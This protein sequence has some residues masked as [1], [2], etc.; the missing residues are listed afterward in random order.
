MS[1]E[2]YWQSACMAIYVRHISRSFADIAALSDVGFTARAGEI[3][4]FA[5]LRRFKRQLQVCV[6]GP[7]S[8]PEAQ[9]L[10]PGPTPR[11]R[12]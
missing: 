8:G 6:Q 4:V 1:S 12:R 9:R 11:R 2:A 3:P 5:V 7:R 10:A